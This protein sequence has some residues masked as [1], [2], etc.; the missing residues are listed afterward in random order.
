M[1]IYL[2]PKPYPKTIRIKY[3]NKFW[4][5]QI[6][7]NSVKC[8]KCGE[9][10]EITTAIVAEQLEQANKEVAAPMEIEVKEEKK[11]HRELQDALA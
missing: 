7:I 2:K 11:R 9:E 5:Y 1:Y 4:Y 10:V 3:I 6:M 8:P